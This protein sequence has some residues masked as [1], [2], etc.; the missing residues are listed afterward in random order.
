MTLIQILA[1]V[2]GGLIILSYF[3]DFKRIF[4]KMSNDNKKEDPA[5]II[6]TPIALQPKTAEIVEQW[7]KLRNMCQSSN[8]IE[9]TA[10]LEEVFPL[11][12]KRG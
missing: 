1:L 6:D 12:V 10:K 11:F 7:D 3:V 4:I 9:A 2:A 8:L 5:I